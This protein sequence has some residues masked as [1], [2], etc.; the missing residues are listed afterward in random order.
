MGHAASTELA[1]IAPNAEIAELEDFT[2]LVCRYRPRVLRFLLLSL[3]D[4][5]V[6]ET[7]AQECFLR[8]YR[9]RG[10]FRG[11]SKLGTWLTQ[12]A[13]NL[14]RDY[15]RNRRFQFW[16]RTQGSGEIFDDLSRSVADRS[17]SQEAALIAKEQVKV[18]WSVAA[19][20]SEKQRTVFLLR[21]VEDLDLFRDCGNYR[22]ERGNG[23]IAPFQ[24]RQG[25]SETPQGGVMNEHL[26]PARISELL[27]VA[28]DDREKAH[29][30]ACP[31]CS[32]ELAELRSAI[33]TFGDA[34]RNL[35][36][37]QVS[38]ELHPGIVAPSRKHW[39]NASRAG[40]GLATA[41]ALALLIWL[42][43]HRK[44]ESER[45]A[46]L[47]AQNDEILM[48]QI[49]TQVSRRVPA[50]IRRPARQAQFGRSTKCLTNQ[51]MDTQAGSQGNGE[52][53]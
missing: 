17:S 9:A 50:A 13:V 6:A 15:S 30:G 25:G 27:I 21:F 10:K 24:G 7:L 49:D 22:N 4:H 51:T 33:S 2:S 3:R 12:I 35:S 14:V 46:L 53:Q 20:L 45:I 16:K 52:K 42:P 23:E 40:W 5:D 29:I 39:L 31:A 34:A 37:P 41:C 44:N 38:R 19:K 11:E 48:E 1:V 36:V 18:V 43:I 28:Q 32:A 47:N 8:A 26:R